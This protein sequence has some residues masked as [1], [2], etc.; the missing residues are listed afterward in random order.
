MAPPA[1]RTTAGTSNSV[2]AMLPPAGTIGPVPAAQHPETGGGHAAEAGQ[3]AA[4]SAVRGRSSRH[5]TQAR[6]P[7]T[8]PPHPI[9]EW[10]ARQ[11]T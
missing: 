6:L 5:P 2:G 8:V 11:R 4:A 9:G 7:R 3:Q 10:I 1:S